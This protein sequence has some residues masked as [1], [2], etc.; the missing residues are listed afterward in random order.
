MSQ[1]SY[2]FL[3]SHSFFGSMFLVG[4]YI[5]IFYVRHTSKMSLLFSFQLLF[6][7]TRRQGF[8]APSVP[9][10]TFSLDSFRPSLLAAM[11]TGTSLSWATMSLQRLSAT[12]HHLRL[13]YVLPVNIFTPSVGHPPF[14]LSY[15]C[16]S[17]FLHDWKC[18]RSSPAVINSLFI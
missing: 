5:Y 17:A 13:T 9:G 12:T 4:F 10:R 8:S 15:L 6:R 2:L 16:T 3:V 14:P 7:A 18:H 1:T 11:G